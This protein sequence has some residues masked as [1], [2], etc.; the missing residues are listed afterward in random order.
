MSSLD[1]RVRL[2]AF[3]FLDHQ[4]QLYGETVSRR[5]LERGFD[6]DGV[7]VPLLGPSGIFKPAV[8]ELP[9]SITSVPPV[10]GKPR[11][12]DDQ[13]DSS[14]LL[15]YRY[16]GTDPNHRDNV[17]LRQAMTYRVPLIYFLGVVPGRYLPSWPAFIVGDDPASLTFTVAIDEQRLP[18]QTADTDLAEQEIRRRY[19]TR[20]VQQRLHQQAF[21]ERVIAAYRKH[22]AICRLQHQE[23]LDAAHIVADTSPDGDPKVSNGLALCK[24]HHAAFDCGIIGIRPDYVV[25]IRVDVLEEID[26][27]MLKHG[28]QEF[29]DASLYVPAQEPLQPDRRLLQHR[30]SMF[31]SR[32]ADAQ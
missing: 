1:Q 11:P 32:G 9:L 28:L 8:L 7:R 16:R 15:K 12:Y 26:G 29:H 10:P 5:V 17:G 31:L 13:I 25:H 24:L 22:C 6:M 3:R 20:I 27:P 23:L 4:R 30:Y 2:A 18:V 14:G 19:A 21:R